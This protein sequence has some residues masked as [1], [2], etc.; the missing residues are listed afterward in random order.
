MVVVLLGVQARRLVYIR[1]CLGKREARDVHLHLAVVDLAE[2]EKVLHDAG[3]AVG[4]IDDDAHE[5]IVK[6]ARQ[7]VSGGDDGFSVGFDV[8]KRRPQLVRH[9]RNELAPRLLAFSLLGHVVDDDQRAALR[10][11]GGKR[12]HEKLQLAVARRFL[13]L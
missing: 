1:N 3:H 12:R 7:L 5:V 10:L 8:G 6:L 9:V 2:C 4:F 13:R 11:I